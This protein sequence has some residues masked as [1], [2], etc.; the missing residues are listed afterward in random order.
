MN[1]GKWKRLTALALLLLPA[2][3]GGESL[4]LEAE[5]FSG[6]PIPYLILPASLTDIHDQAFDGCDAVLIV[7]AGS[8]A[9]LWVESRGMEHLI[10]PAE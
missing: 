9:A 3:A 6:A 5:A 4:S 8:P 1:K 10:L 2:C 7:E